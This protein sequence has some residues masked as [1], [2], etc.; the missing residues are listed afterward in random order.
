MGIGWKNWIVNR[1]KFR[2]MKR[3]IFDIIYKTL[4]QETEAYKFKNA[5]DFVEVAAEIAEKVLAVVEQKTGWDEALEWA[6][7]RT[8]DEDG[9]ITF[10]D[11]EPY[12]S[13]SEGNWKHQNARVEFK[14]IKYT[15]PNWENS[16]QQ[17]PK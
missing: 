8:V 7:Y 3:Q 12:R 6:T 9:T 13:D 16:L 2:T 15:S 10:W 14:E 11:L 17:L 1:F 5:R 4:R